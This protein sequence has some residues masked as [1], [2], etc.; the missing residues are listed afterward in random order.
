MNDRDNILER[1]EEVERMID[2]L[3][4]D[5]QALRDSY[6][7]ADADKEGTVDEVFTNILNNIVKGGGS[8]AV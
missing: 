8:N 5:V 1:L 2:L 7:G 6:T 3:R 4:R